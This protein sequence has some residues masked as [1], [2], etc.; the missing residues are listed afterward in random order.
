M[1]SPHSDPAAGPDS[2]AFGRPAVPPWREVCAML[3]WLAALMVLPYLAAMLLA[4]LTFA[5]SGALGGLQGAALA[6]AVK[7]QITPPATGFWIVS[8][9]AAALMILLAKAIAVRR[10][11]KRWRAAIGLLP[12]P[13]SP[14]LAGQLALLLAGYFAWAALAVFALK[15][16]WPA[17][18]ILPEITSAAPVGAGASAAAFVFLAVLVPAAEEM[19]FRGYAF[20]RLRSVF[21][22]AAV[23][24][25]TAALFALAHFN[26][27]LL[28]PLVTAYLGL[29]T[30]WL[31]HARG[32]LL[33]GLAL[34]GLVNGLA[35]A[36]MLAR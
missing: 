21:G 17:Q 20:A 9:F 12:V 25:L 27:G 5:I 18:V 32:S 33:P 16:L 7:Q 19:A 15:S 34:H 13:L 31:R 2:D 3:L 14:R 26:G 36:A 29:A 11:G 24:G 4:A 28:H 10:F 22:P 35:V 8:L 6:G 30:G 1:N 23:I